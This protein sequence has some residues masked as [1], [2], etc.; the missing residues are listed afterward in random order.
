MLS[1]QGV[2]RR[3]VVHSS[4]AAVHASSLATRKGSRTLALATLLAA[5]T[6]LLVDVPIA[7]AF[8]SD[9][10]DWCVSAVGAEAYC[11]NQAGGAFT[12]GQCKDTVPSEAPSYV[13]PNGGFFIP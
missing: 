4:K 13:P 2:W 5:V 1:V 12:G 8:D 10:Y 11:C 6:G 7:R 9:Y 3:V